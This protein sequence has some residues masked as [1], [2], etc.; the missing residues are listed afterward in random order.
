VTRVGTVL[1]GQVVS[2]KVKAG[3]HVKRGQPLAQL[4]DLEQRMAL[5]GAAGQVAS[6][7]LADVRAERELTSIL[8]SEYSRGKLPEDWSPDEILDGAAGDA[9][10]ELFHSGAQLAKHHAL[11][12]LTRRQLARRLIRSPVDGNILERSV[13]PGE[14]IGS[15]PPGPALFV[16]GSD[17]SVLRITAAIGAAY[18]PRL[19]PGPA[20]FEVG[21]S[22]DH[23]FPATIIGV[24]P[25]HAPERSSTA[26]E[27]SLHTPNDGGA[28][29]PGMSALVSLP[30]E[31]PAGALHVPARA[32]ARL[33]RPPVLMVVDQRGTLTTVPVRVGVTDDVSAEVEGAGIRAGDL[34][35]ADADACGVMP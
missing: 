33:P 1:P 28:L 9:Q 32:V 34:V 6:A 4:D 20:S 14:S 18:V 30:M 10:I 29:I 7:E 19:Q 24:A 8:E 16:I 27:V 13:A 2:V 12:A 15:S 26:Y 31:S 11:L 21:A 25:A 22:G 3:D 17:P 23:P 35:L 5:V